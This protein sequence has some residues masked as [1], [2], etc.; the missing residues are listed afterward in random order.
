MSGKVRQFN[1]SCIAFDIWMC[2]NISQMSLTQYFTSKCD[3]LINFVKVYFGYNW[4][5][6]KSALYFEIPAKYYDKF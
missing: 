4:L 2:G 1:E 3:T 5:E 6:G